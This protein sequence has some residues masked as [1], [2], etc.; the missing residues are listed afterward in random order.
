[1]GLGFGVLGSWGLGF[2]VLDYVVWGLHLFFGGRLRMTC[3]GPGV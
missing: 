1:M 2:R 3:L